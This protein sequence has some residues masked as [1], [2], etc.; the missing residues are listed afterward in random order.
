M[1][2]ILENSMICLFFRGDSFLLAL[3][4]VEQT[5]LWK[6]SC[7]FLNDGVHLSQLASHLVVVRTKLVSRVIHPQEV[8]DEHVP[9]AGVSKL[10]CQH[11]L[12][13]I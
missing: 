13:F 6:T 1:K 11:L 10:H 2:K 8:A 5:D 4:H 3:K 12:E 9:V 7:N